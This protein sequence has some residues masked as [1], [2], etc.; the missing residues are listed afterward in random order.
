MGLGV[1]GTST[2]FINGDSLVGALPY[3]VFEQA[4]RLAEQGQLGEALQPSP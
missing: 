1:R 2:L 4:I 3:E